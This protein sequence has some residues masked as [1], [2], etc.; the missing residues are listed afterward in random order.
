MQQTC[1]VVKEH[2]TFPDVFRPSPDAMNWHDGW[3]NQP[4]KDHKTIFK[5][6]WQPTRKIEPKIQAISQSTLFRSPSR[7]TL[8]RKHIYR[9]KKWLRLVL[10]IPLKL[11]FHHFL[12]KGFQTNSNQSLL[13]FGLRSPETVWKTKLDKSKPSSFLTVLM[14][15]CRAQNH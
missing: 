4:L 5:T 2:F 11:L 12:Q 8:F 9:N 1:L 6:K 13:Q 14:A 15:L 3:Q 7:T 10:C